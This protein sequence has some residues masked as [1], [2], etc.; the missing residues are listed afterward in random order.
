[1]SDEERFEIL[2]DVIIEKVSELTLTVNIVA[3]ERE[4]I[5]KVQSNHFWVMVTDGDLDEMIERLAPL[6][7][8]RQIQKIPEK[9]LNIQDLLTVK[10]TVEFGPQHERMTVDKYRRKVEGFIRELVKSNPV[11]QKIAQGDIVTD[12][13]IGELADILKEHYPHITEYILREVYDNRSA[14]V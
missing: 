9:K 3:K 11:L 12:E 4:W 10:E 6:M 1:M 2:K 14:T 5:E 13:E 8:F 7:K